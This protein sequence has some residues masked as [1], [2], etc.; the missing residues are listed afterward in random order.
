MRV[1]N[2]NRLA[3]FFQNLLFGMALSHQLQRLLGLL[4]KDF[5][6]VLNVDGFR[7]W[8]S[9]PVGVVEGGTPCSGP[10]V[11]TSSLP[12]HGANFLE[13]PA[14]RT[15]PEAAREEQDAATTSCKGRVRWRKQSARKGHKEGWRAATNG[16]D[17]RKPFTGQVCCIQQAWEKSVHQ[18]QKNWPVAVPSYVVARA[19]PGRVLPVEQGRI[20][21]MAGC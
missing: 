9:S 14:H 6:D 2:A 8:F 11:G 10:L 7:H 17:R 1:K 4:A 16:Q 21:C 15:A 12:T 19:W 18:S 13:R 20:T 5:E 3:R